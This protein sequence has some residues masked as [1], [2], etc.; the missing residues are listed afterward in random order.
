[1][2]P[3]YIRKCLSLILLINIYDIRETVIQSLYSVYIVAKSKFPGR[4]VQYQ[5][6]QKLPGV[7]PIGFQKYNQAI[8]TIIKCRIK[9]TE[10]GLEER[11]EERGR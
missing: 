8:I 9:E 4:W 5:K 1:M 11:K 10:L 2:K 6:N 3:L 7:Y